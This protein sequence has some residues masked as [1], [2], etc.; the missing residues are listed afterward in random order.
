LSLCVVPSLDPHPY[1]RWFVEHTGPAGCWPTWQGE[2]SP[3]TYLISLFQTNPCRPSLV[4]TWTLTLLPLCTLP[5][6]GPAY[7]LVACCG[8]MVGEPRPSATGFRQLQSDAIDEP[9]R[10]GLTNAMGLRSR[11][12]T[13]PTRYSHVCWRD[14]RPPT[15]YVLTPRTF[16]PLL[17]IRSRVPA[18]LTHAVAHPRAPHLSM[19]CTPVARTLRPCPA[20]RSPC[21]SCAARPCHVSVASL[22]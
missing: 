10:S 8:E 6:F 22:P 19:P 9:T 11:R 17:L 3:A 1:P 20:R 15:L 21:S 2:L 4:D 14:A 16:D 18:A 5:S 13:P 7:L 12:H